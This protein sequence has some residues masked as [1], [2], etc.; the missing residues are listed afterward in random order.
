[1]RKTIIFLLQVGFT[2]DFVFD[3]PLSLNIC[4]TK[5]VFPK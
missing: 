2:G 4:C 3:C 1:V 5:P